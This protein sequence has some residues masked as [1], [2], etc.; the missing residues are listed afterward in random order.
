MRKLFIALLLLCGLP[1]LATTWNVKT[2]CGAVGNGSTNDTAAINTCIGQ[3]VTGDMLLFP[4]GTY[5]VTSLNGIT[6]NNITIDGSS[7]TATIKSTTTQQGP[8]FRVGQ[9]GLGVNSVTCSGWPGTGTGVALS[10]TANEL[11]TSFT[12][13]SPLSGASVGGYALILQGG[14]YGNTGGGFTSDTQCDTASGCRSEIAKIKGIS[15]S[16]YTVDTMLHDTYSPSINGA[17]ACAVTGIVSG[18]TLQN[19][20]LDG[21]STTAQTSGNTWGVQFNDCINCTISGVTFKNTLGSALLHSLNYGDTFNNITITG[22]GSENCGSAMLGFVNSNV[23]LTGISLSGLNP[24]TSRGP[25]LGNGAFGLEEN[26]FT[27]STMSNSTVNSSGTGGGRPFKTEDNRYSTYNTVTVENSIGSFNGWSIDWWSAHNIVENSNILNN[28]GGS[29]NA[30]I[31]IFGEMTSNIT[32]YNNTMTG[33]GNVQMYDSLWYCSGTVYGIACPQTTDTNLSFYNNT[34]GGS[35]TVGLLLS[36]KNDCVNGNTFQSGLG[37]GISVGGT[38]TVGSGNTLNLNSS[39]LVAGS[40]STTG[41]NGSGALATPSP[42]SLS[43]GSQTV[44]VTSS[45]LSVTSSNKISTFNGTNTLTFIGTPKLQTGTQFAVSANS[46]TSVAAGASCTTSV[47]F[48]P[49]SS[50][51][52]TDNLIFLDNAGGAYQIVPVS[53]TGGGSVQPPT[54]LTATVH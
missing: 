35:G 28:A 19:I 38:G 33:N 53:G 20:I 1:A 14:K 27:N 22:A 13:T 32:F 21:G 48:T 45:P 46:C 41:A 8:F 34:F 15:S 26:E 40:C 39:N 25:C 9:S 6:V 42:T 29:G 18:I 51:P 2:N 5:L 16:T 7:N 11:S 17:I 47:T 24:G 52:Q 30:G 3:M 37:T 43:F 54:G 44:G 31:N 10:S 36:N 12:T 50:G 4:A 49:L 23:T